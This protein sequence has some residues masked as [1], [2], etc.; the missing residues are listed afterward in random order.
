MEINSSQFSSQITNKVNGAPAAKAGEVHSITIKERTGK[1]EAKVVLKGQEVTVKFDDPIPS[2]EKILVE[3]KGQTPD[4]KIILKTISSI[5][6]GR[7]DSKV[8]L[9]KAGFDLFLDPEL[10]EAVNQI[11]SR[12]GKLSK[13]SLAGIQEFLKKE[14]G[15]VEEKVET[16]K[17]AQQRGIEFAHTPLRSVHAALQEFESVSGFVTE[18]LNKSSQQA[19]IDSK[20]VEIDSK[21]IASPITMVNQKNPSTMEESISPLPPLSSQNVLVTKVS[22]K[23]SQLAID[24]S[25]AR[26]E[27]G[28]SLD[29]V[30]KLIEV[31]NL[32]NANQ[33][34]EATI[35]KLDKT[36]LKGDFMLYADLSTEKELLRASSKLAEARSLLSKGYTEQGS[37]IV[38]E[39][40]AKFEQLRFQPSEQKVLRFTSQQQPKAAEELL[41]ETIPAPKSGARSIFELVK[42]MGYTH[43]TDTAEALSEKKDVVANLK[44]FLL[45]LE[46]SGNQQPNVA[47]ALAAITGQQLLSRQD[48][49]GVQNLFIQLPLLLNKQI[50]N[51]RVLVNSKRNGEKIDWENCNLYFILETKKLGEIGIS[52]SAVNRQLAITIKSDQKAV[53]EIAKPLTDDMKE[54]LEEIGYNIGSVQFKRF[55]PEVKD[56]PKGK[57]TQKRERGFDLTV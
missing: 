4:G 21:S 14:T 31:K 52:L 22:E 47:K 53:K 27:I 32:P 43:E 40:K 42:T 7:Q 24:F 28:W 29:T 41:A 48:P 6:K 57:P 18:V 10:K 13:E 49:S 46:E 1:N 45:H 56:V 55:T 9:Q 33:S 17:L 8:M 34:L 3:V 15:A 19:T 30:A 37:R 44:S 5:E 36:I 23:L 2:E 39:V 16:L 12:G 38:N 11:L 51:V 50:E 35:T 26:K 20:K 54:K 25:K